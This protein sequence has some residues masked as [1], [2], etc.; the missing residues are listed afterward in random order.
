[1]ADD[2]FTH[3]KRLTFEQAE[4]AEPLPAQLQL[5]E[6][7]QGLRAR[8][9]DVVYRSFKDS[10]EYGDDR[11]YFR[12]P[13][14]SIFEGMHIY[15]YHLMAD[16]FENDFDELVRQTKIVFVDGNYLAVFGWLQWVLR[17]GNAPYEFDEEIGR[18][19]HRSGAAYRLL[20]GRTIVPVGSATELATLEQAFADLVASEF[21]GARAHLRNAA[22]LLTAGKWAD[23]I[24]ES[25]HAVELVAEVLEP[26]GEFSKAMAKLEGSVKIHGA[27]KQGF[28]NLYGY[29]SDQEGIRHP[30]LDEPVAAADE[31]DALFMIG[32][33]AAFVSYLINKARAAGLLEPKQ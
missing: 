10:R 25:I 6:L 7:S 3:R 8:L 11:P 22:E 32:A 19:L 23:S 2:P 14:A 20:E 26:S 4:G 31:A 18:A 28:K 16:E 33:C 13:W 27:L 12:Q 5:K 29:T 17:T 1:M 15:R 21:H 30:L 24:R 9:W